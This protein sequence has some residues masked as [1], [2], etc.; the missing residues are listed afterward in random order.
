MKFPALQAIPALEAGLM[1]VPRV[2]VDA[3][4]RDRVGESVIKRES[5]V[6]IPGFSSL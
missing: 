4:E 5:L 6:V 2:Q 1:S 3:S